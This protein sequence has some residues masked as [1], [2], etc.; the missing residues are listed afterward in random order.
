MQKAPHGPPRL[1][2]SVR[3]IRIMTWFGKMNEALNE[4]REVWLTYTKHRVTCNPVK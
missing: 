1:I 2:P 3:G 4:G